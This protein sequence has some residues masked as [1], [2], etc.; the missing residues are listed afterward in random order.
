LIPV[1]RALLTTLCLGSVLVA[2]QSSGPSHTITTVASTVPF[3]GDV[4][5][6]GIVVVPRTIGKLAKGNLLISN[7]NASSNFQGTGTTIVQIT[8]LE[9]GLSSLTLT[10]TISLALAQVE[11]GSPRRWPC[12]EADG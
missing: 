11:W 2:A 8:P 4:N 1:Y 3:N 12:C 9:T 5:P 6:Y 7:F 10:L